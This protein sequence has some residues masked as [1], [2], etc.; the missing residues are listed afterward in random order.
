[1][2]KLRTCLF[3]ILA[4]FL[5]A[6]N[7]GQGASPKEEKTEKA[8]EISAEKMKQAI[9]ML[10]AESRNGIPAPL[11]FTKE[12]HLTIYKYHLMQAG[13]TKEKYPQLYKSLEQ[14]QKMHLEAGGPPEVKSY[15]VPSEADFQAMSENGTTTDSGYAIVPIQ[16][17][18]SLGSANGTNYNT[19]ALSSVP[20]PLAAHQMILGM[21][22]MQGRS[23]GPTSDTT[24]Y[25][26]ATELAVET[27]GDVGSS[28]NEAQ[29]ILTYFYEDSTGTP[30]HG[31]IY[32]YTSAA[33]DSIQNINPTIQ[34]AGNTEIILCLGRTLGNCD[35]SPEGGSGSNVLL[36][37]TGTIWFGDSIDPIN[38]DSTNVSCLITLARTQAQGGGCMVKST[39][40]F[41]ADPNTHITGN[42][43]TWNLSPA[44]FDTVD[45]CLEKNQNA[46][47]TFTVSVTIRGLPVFVSIT[48]AP[49]TE[50]SPYFLKIPD[51][52]VVWSCLPS[53]TQILMAD[54]SSKS[55]EFIEDN[56]E[57]VADASGRTVKVH[58]VMRGKDEMLYQVQT[59]NG[60]TLRAT[61]GH[62]LMVQRGQEFL[63]LAAKDLK[64]G[65]LVQTSTGLS[66]IS[67]IST[68][69]YDGYV[70]NLVI[71][72]AGKMD[73]EKTAQSTYFADGILVGDSYMQF[74]YGRDEK[75]GSTAHL[76]KV[77]EK[78]QVDYQ[79]YMNR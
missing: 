67:E 60:Y 25:G 11:D 47:Y 74:K 39:D 29:S 26:S 72:P 4:L 48:N 9:T 64:N 20:G 43:L 15:E 3:L 16:Q 66:P 17:I 23:I 14:A 45:G 31:Y 44:H 36:P 33:P 53:G 71:D 46:I 1:M 77:P 56:D 78:W 51:L 38:S 2:F 73:S 32:G 18:T 79:N 76:T 22:D 28:E 68:E 69:P 30:Y 21:Y 5:N 34:V 54:G 24:V 6:C 59:R 7:S 19:S 61:K 27:T 35:Y 58:S 50:P 55:I 40:N 37:I 41:F 8:E 49:D 75:Q 62:T 52:K 12:H 57:V 70:W 63:P 13:Y 10:A 42:V 65:D